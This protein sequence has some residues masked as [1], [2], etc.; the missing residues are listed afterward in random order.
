MNMIAAIPFAGCRFGDVR[1]VCA[2][3]HNAE[4]EY[5]VL[6]PFIKDGFACGRLRA[7]PN[8]DGPRATFAVSVLC[9]MSTA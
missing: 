1:R 2:F 3:F 9:E 4:E 5:G 6:F 7:A 8:K